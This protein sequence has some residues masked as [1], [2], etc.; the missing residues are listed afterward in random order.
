MARR[1]TWIKCT[2]LLVALLAP[3]C[4]DD[5][6]GTGSGGGSASTMTVSSATSQTAAGSTT[7]ATSS[8]STS[9]GGG[10]SGGAGSGTMI[11]CE[12]FDSRE[13]PASWGFGAQAGGSVEVSTDTSQNYGGSPGSVRGTYP[14][15][16]GGVYVWG[17]Y[18]LS[19]LDLSELFIEFRARMPAAKQGL[20]FL[21]VFGQD[22]SGGYANTTFGLDYTGVDFGAMYQVSFGDGS[23][24]ANDTANVINFDG[25]FPEWIGRSFGTATVSTPQGALWAS[26]S[27]GD[28]WHHFRLGLRFNSGTSEADEIADG[29]YYVEIDGAVY[30][31]AQG[32]FNRHP[33]NGPIRNV[34]LFGWSQNGSEPFELW[35]DDV[36]LST[37]GFL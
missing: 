4:G 14:T 23:S 15:A 2:W 5:A 30:V 32:L 28:D 3:A 21:K 34:E 19:S 35:Y 31:D 25:G 29:A 9:A 24:V 1:F 36:C 8:V 27:W 16:S 33:T 18:D 37:G 12:S 13:L 7:S 17:G 20:K 11:A 6:T 22:E 26:S 10:G